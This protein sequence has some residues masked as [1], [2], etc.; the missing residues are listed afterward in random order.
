MKLVLI[1]A[2][3]LGIRSAFAQELSVNL[4]KPSDH[5]DDFLDARNQFPTGAFHGFFKSLAMLRRRFPDRYFAIVWDGGY[6]CRMKLTTEAVE[7]GTIPETYKE[8][9]RGK[10]APQQIVDF[11]RQRPDL[12]RAI[13]CTNIP[14]MMVKGEEADDTIASYVARY[15]TTFETILLATEDKDYFQLL[16]P[17][18]SVFRQDEIYTDTDFF[19][20]FQISPSQWVDVA[21]LMG[22]A[23]DNIFGIPGWGIQTALEA[24]RTHKTCEAVL[25]SLHSRWDYLIEKH[26][27]LN[28]A[29]FA[30]LADLK[31]P[32]GKPKYPLLQKGMPFTGVAMALEKKQV[33]I[34]KADLFALMHAAKVPLAK[35]LKTMR[36]F[37]VPPLPGIDGTPAWNRQLQS[38]FLKFC[39]HYQLNEVS[40]DA[41]LLCAPQVDAMV[42]I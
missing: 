24:I 12:I 33:K 11:N 6:D 39:A 22:E 21:G 27:D 26:P 17:G 18:V 28:E 1:D 37:E 3:N 4:S 2:N 42:S 8:N 29:D 41:E 31:T 10:A 16:S 34:P 36:I 32:K 40:Y 35:T 25:A 38:K 7:K 13:S 5:P 30:I 20:A 15:R 9:R 23:G 19:N 14:Q